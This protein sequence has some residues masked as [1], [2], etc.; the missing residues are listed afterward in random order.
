MTVHPVPLIPMPALALA[1]LF[2]SSP[3][4]PPYLKQDW[5]DCLRQQD[6]L[7]SMDNHST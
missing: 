1:L 4:L 5:Q 3:I 7:N 2:P 6:N